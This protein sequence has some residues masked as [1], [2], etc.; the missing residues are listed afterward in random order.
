MKTQLL[1]LLLLFIQ[2]PLIAQQITLSNIPAKNLLPTGDIYSIFQ[3]SEGLMWYA[4]SKEGLF[5]YDGYDVK[6]FRSDSNTPDLLESNHITCITEDK[7]RK[8]W[9]GTKRGVYILD[10]SN[11]QVMPLPD[12]TIKGWVINAIFATSDGSIWVGTKNELYR[13][14]AQGQKLGVYQTY[15]HGESRN[16]YHLYEDSQ[17]TLWVI[18]W[19]GG[20]FKYDVDQDRFI[21][22]PWAFQENPTCIIE[23]SKS[24]YFWIGTW[25]KGIVRFDPKEKDPEKMFVPQTATEESDPLRKQINSIAQDSVRGN[26]WVTTM[27]DLYV[28]EI[29]EENSLSPLPTT[30]FLPAGKKIVHNISSDRSGRLWIASNYPPSFILSFQQASITRY[31]LPLVKE[32]LGFPVAPLNLIYEKGSYWFWQ[33][34]LNLSFYR[35]ADNHFTVYPHGGL[36]AAFEQSKSRDGIFAIKHNSQVI[37]IQV[38]NDSLTESPVCTIPAVTHERIRGLHEDYSGN[39]WIGTSY[40]LFRYNLQTKEMHKA[41]ENTGIINCIT[42]SRNGDIF[43]ATE[44]NGFLRLSPDG[45]KSQYSPQE[46]HNY[47]RLSVTPGGNVWVKTQHNRIYYYNSQA[48]TFTQY[49]F[50]YD[51]GGD[52]IHDILSDNENNLWILSD[53][54]IIVYNTAKQTFRMI[55]NTDP[56]INLDNFLS[57]CKDEEGKVHVGGTNGIVVLK[58]SNQDGLWSERAT[59]MQVKC[60][61]AWYKTNLAYVCYAL[62]ALLLI[63]VF[64]W[65]YMAY[66]KPEQQQAFEKE[67]E[68]TPNDITIS[69]PDKEFI[70]NVLNM[71]EKNISNSE[72]SI[73]DLS[74]DMAMSRVSLYRKI[75]SITGNTPTEFVKTIRLKRAAELLKKGKLTV[76]E[77]AYEVG[78][79]SP[80]YFTQAFKKMFGVL[81]TNYR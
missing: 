28:Y 48:Q 29:T 62:A 46:D 70:E 20:L 53:Q 45:K 31:E 63:S 32:K 69:S 78:F 79:S 54:K 37:H 7:E 68:V 9:F 66:Q 11:Y 49:T 25:G 24:P 81:P 14:N 17:H 56:S 67:T 40:N 61:P 41:W 5:R 39:L 60:L 80:S 55:R 57:I 22:Y 27:K 73:E 6:A 36:L 75:N 33:L 21:P 65:K 26:V 38:Q 12:Q 18:Q 42:S 58:A 47:A 51:F 52:V 2:I 71:I 59:T 44:S 13:Y 19:R 64:V 77:V 15:W 16:I 74:Q 23:D 10:K 43:V 1:I 76:S 4:T 30:D 8:I 35:V 50:K 72:Y 34:R 3:D